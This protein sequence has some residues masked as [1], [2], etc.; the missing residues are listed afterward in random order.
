MSVSGCGEGVPST[1]LTS[2]ELP[3]VGL[4]SLPRVSEVLW[5]CVVVEGAGQ[6]AVLHSLQDTA[7]RVLIPSCFAGWTVILWDVWVY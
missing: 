3:L 6:P 2:L 1:P 5:L 4:S 7:D